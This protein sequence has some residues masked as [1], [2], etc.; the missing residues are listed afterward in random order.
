MRIRVGV[1]GITQSSRD[2]AERARWRPVLQKLVELQHNCDTRFA[3]DANGSESAA[4]QSSLD[5]A[6]VSLSS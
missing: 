2:G 1:R 5:R 4:M 6:A 3:G